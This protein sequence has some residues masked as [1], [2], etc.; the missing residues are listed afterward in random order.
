MITVCHPADE[1]EQMLIA[2]QLESSGIPYFINAEHFGSLYPG[3][4][5]PWYNE[6]AI[7]VPPSCVDEELIIINEFRKHYLPQSESLDFV[8]KV[9]IL[10]EA[11]FFGWLFPCG[12]K[13]KTD[14][15]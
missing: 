7:R 1:I 14:D 15:A 6:K 9:R 3:M 4:Q 2:S 10:C 11:L 12:R 8:S 5:I 13:K